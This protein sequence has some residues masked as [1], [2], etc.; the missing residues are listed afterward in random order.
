[1]ILQDWKINLR[2]ALQQPL[3]AE[4]AHIKAAPLE[5]IEGLENKKWPKDAKMSAVTFLLYPKDGCIYTL[6]MKR[7]IYSGVHSGQI[8]L[9]GGQKEKSDSHLLHTAIREYKE[10][11]GLLLEE[12]N[13]LAPLSK[14]YIPPSNFLVQPYVAVVEKLGALTPD[15]REVQSL[16]EISLSELFRSENYGLKEINLRDKKGI[17]LQVKAPCYQ[18]KGLRIWGA[19]AMLISELQMIFIKN[20]IPTNY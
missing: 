12:S 15:S 3:P 13:Y 5:R 20:G 9:P 14:L 10:E 17:K 4:Q 16:H 7:P 2:D 18:V 8:S 19:T 11:T 1:M 6:F